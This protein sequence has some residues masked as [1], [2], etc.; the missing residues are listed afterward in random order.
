MN[1]WLTMLLAGLVTFTIRLSFIWFIGHRSIPPLMRRALRLVPPAVL[2]AIIF[3][4]VFMPSGQLDLSFGNARLLAAALATL[5][6]WRTRN[7]L[8]TIVIGMLAVW[9]FQ[10][11]LG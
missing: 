9:L 5:V 10:W 8:L 11:L 1:I 2:T 4:E 6:A 3:P 7:A